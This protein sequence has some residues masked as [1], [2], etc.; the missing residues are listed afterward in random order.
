M[1]KSSISVGTILYYTMSTR[2]SIPYKQ[3]V[4]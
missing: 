3:P 2:S 4:I 1:Y